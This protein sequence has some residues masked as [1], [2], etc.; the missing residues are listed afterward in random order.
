MSK[1]YGYRLQNYAYELISDDVAGEFQRNLNDWKIH[2][3]NLVLYARKAL[4]RHQ[5]H[6][7]EIKKKLEAERAERA[8][9]AMFVLSLISGPALSFVSGA[10]QYRLGPKLFGNRSSEIRKSANPKYVRPEPPKPFPSGTGPAIKPELKRPPELPK[11]GKTVSVQQPKEPKFNQVEVFDPDWSKT[12]GKI[13]GDLGS[14]LVNDFMVSPALKAAE[15]NQSKLQNAI[16]RVPDSVDLEAMQTNLDNTWIEAQSAG[17]QAIQFFA[18]T[19]REDSTW[20][21]RFWDKAIKGQLVGVPK[22]G[23]DLARFNNGKTWIRA[24]V[25]QQR[26]TWAKQ[27]GWFYYGNA[28]AHIT[29]AHTINAIESEMWAY[30]LL[31]RIFNRY[32]K[33]TNA[34]A[35]TAGEG[36][37]STRR[38]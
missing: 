12:K 25:D 37:T 8:Q 11:A 9:L 29:E 30:G 22:T 35:P 7:E 2:T 38:S 5:G 3:N 24:V 33:Y 26:E 32:A 14:K 4:A 19:I 15:P 21:D 20:G 16:D 17:K 28:P 36:P 13:L 6:L 10:I 27:D 23:D 34:R 1:D 31:R 18:N